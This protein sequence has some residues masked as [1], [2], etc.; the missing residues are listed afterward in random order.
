MLMILNLVNS[1][2]QIY[3]LIIYIKEIILYRMNKI[4]KNYSKFNKNM[5]KN[6]NNISMKSLIVT[7]DNDNV[8]QKAIGGK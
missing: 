8:S 1:L 6:K 3:A 2:D 4:Y 5:N 7:K